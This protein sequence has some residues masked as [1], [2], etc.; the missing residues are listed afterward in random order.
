MRPLHA[1]FAL[2]LATLARPAAAVEP[3]EPAPDYVL[4]TPAGAT[5]RLSDLR[6]RLVLLALI[7][8]G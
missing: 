7:G 5:E 3:G 1:A 8:W 6:G 2:L 4:Q